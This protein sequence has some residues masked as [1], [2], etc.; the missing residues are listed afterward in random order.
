M[1][2]FTA[3]LIAGAV[4]Q[5]GAALWAYSQESGSAEEAQ[6]ILDTAQAKYGGINPPALEKAAAEVL[7]P[8]KLA[9]IVEN[10][11]YR[12]AQGEALASLKQISDEGGLTATDKA[13]LNRVMNEAQGAAK[14][15][16]ATILENFRNRGALGSGLELSARMGSAANAAQAQQQAGL[17]IAGMAQDRARRAIMDRGQLAAQ[18]SEA[19]WR[20]QSATARA[21]DEIDKANWGER[22]DVANENQRRAQ[23]DYQN[24]LSQANRQLGIAGQQAGAVREAGARRANLGQQIGGA[25]SSTAGVV[26]RAYTAPTDAAPAFGSSVTAPYAPPQT[27][28]YTPKPSDEQLDADARWRDH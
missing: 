26:G 4:S 17:D 1:D 19:D 16:E 12:Q 13:N 23:Q 9:Q 5:I 8:T 24:Q 15:R 10:P 2:P 18:Y 22:R 14:S 11:A 28:T 25:L 20:R 27:V 6:K 7:G 3:F 21:Q